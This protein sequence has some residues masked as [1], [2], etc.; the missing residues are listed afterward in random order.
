MNHPDEAPKLNPWPFLAGDVVLLASA[1]LIAN[2][3]RAPLSGASLIVVGGFVALGAVLGVVPFLVNYTRRQE[4]ALA[5]RQS[6]IAALAQSTATSAEQLSIAAAGLNSIAEISTKNLKAAESLPH[7]LQ[8][9]INDFK[10]QLNEVAVIEN[11]SLAQEINT[12][13]SSETERLEA[14]LT[15]VRKTV[16]ELSTLES[17]VRKHLGEIHVALAQFS[18]SG[19]KIATEHAHSLASVRAESEKSLHALRNAALA[20]IESAVAKAFSDIEVKFQQLP[21]PAPALRETA[22]L[23]PVSPIQPERIHL[24]ET[25]RESAPSNSPAPEPVADR[26]SA[27]STEATP[28]PAD[29]E[30]S[31][32]SVVDGSLQTTK[33][34]A[35]SVEAVTAAAVTDDVKVA[36]KRSAR[37]ASSEN[38]LSLGL[39]LPPDDFAQTP[40]EEPVSPPAVSADGLTRLVATAYIG[41]GNKLFIRGEGPGLSWEKGVPLQFVSIGKWRWET[42]DADRPVTFKLFKNDEVECA[43]VGSVTFPAGYQQEVR[44]SF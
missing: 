2:Q 27:T 3:A 37:K 28:S 24:V 6:E 43:V 20:S 5:E 38:E 8:E 19:N 21:K 23:P 32:S 39:D 22:P 1:Y 44:A 12:L 30:S 18:S 31:S 15:N 4:L 36:R 14:A 10:T 34:E 33:P 40:S 29:L 42:A 35:D 9:K 41:I 25:T 13:R 26:A 11:E 16:S 7:K 17:T